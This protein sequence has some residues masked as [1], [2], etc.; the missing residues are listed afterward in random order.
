MDL[1]RLEVIAAVTALAARFPGLRL[2]ADAPSPTGL[3]FRK[4]DRLPVVLR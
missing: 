3:V 1:A 4:P 2:A